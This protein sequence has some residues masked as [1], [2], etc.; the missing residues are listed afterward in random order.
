VSNTTDSAVGRIKAAYESASAGLGGGPEWTRRR[1][2]ALARL[3]AHGLPDRRDENWKYLDWQELG[4]RDLGVRASVPGDAALPAGT[5]A[6]FAA[7]RTVLLLD[8]R[9]AAGP[10]GLPDGVEVESLSTALERDPALAALALS[11][12][13]DHAD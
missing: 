10:S 12:P 6:G 5:V 8:G 1:E 11:V 9:W 13:G 3:V 7:G 4:A 2:A